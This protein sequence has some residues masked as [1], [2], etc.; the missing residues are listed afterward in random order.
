ME[1]SLKERVAELEERIEELENKEK[2]RKIWRII[3]AIFR[4]VI[5][6]A[7]VFG[8]VKAYYYI[9]NEYVKPISD[10]IGVDPE[11][12]GF[13]LSKLTEWIKSLK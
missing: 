3:K 10:S 4:L 9:R 11:K 5:W 1:T 12:E 6:G 8:C 7:L 13:D 2:K